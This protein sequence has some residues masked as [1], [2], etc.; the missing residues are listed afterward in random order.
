MVKCL[1]ITLLVCLGFDLHSQ[2]LTGEETVR[3]Y[4]S[5]QKRLLVRSTATFTNLITQ[6]NLDHDSVVLIACKVTGLPFLL[7]YTDDDDN[8]SPSP[9]AGLINAGKIPEA[10]HFLKGLDG[11]MRLQLSIELANW[12]LHKAGTHE[13]DLDSAN[14]FIQDALRISSAAKNKNKRYECLGLLGE[15]YRQIGDIGESKRTYFHLISSSQKEGD[16]KITASS[17]HH[18]ALLDREIDSTDLVYLDNSIVLYQQLQSKEKEIEILWMIASYHRIYDM[19]LYKKDLTRILE[20][21]QSIGFRHSLFAEYYLSLVDLQKAKYLDALEHANAAI[22]NMKWSRLSTMQGTFYMRL[23]AV[24]WGFEKKEEALVSFKK[25][26]ENRSDE[27]RIFWF[28]SLLFATSLLWEMNRPEESLSMMQDITSEFPP[29]TP[30]EQ[31]QIFSIKGVCYDKVNNYRLA[32]EN[33][34]AFLE[35]TNKY[36]DFDPY[37]ELEETYLEIAQFYLSKSN[38][39]T[40]RLFVNKAMS[41]SSQSMVGYAE[42]S[43]LLFK[44]DSIAGDYKS[45]MK[46]Y[47]QYKYFADIDKNMEQRKK[48]DEL[49][50]KYGAEKKDND[51]KLLQKE[52]QLQETMLLQAKYTRNWI[53]GGVALLLIIVGLLVYN[54]RLKQRTNKKLE[55]QQTEIEKQNFT[56]RH[57]VDEKDWLAKEIHHRVK[58]NLQIVMSLLNSQSAYIENDAALTAIHDS[59]HRVHAM[60]LIHQ[61][62]YNADNVSSIDMSF[63]IREL[64]SYLSD[65]FGTRQRILFEFAIEPLELDVSQAVPLGLILNEAITN[66]IKYAFPEGRSGVV[67]ISLFNTTSNNYLL[68]ISDNGIGIPSHLNDKKPGSLGMSLIAGLSEDLDGSFSIENNNGTTIKISFA[69]DPAVKRSDIRAVPFASNI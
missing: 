50:I 59:Q 53:L 30:W 11:E 42:K 1:T 52:K 25:A 56:L 62:L 54:T 5:A 63:Y 41:R 38:L 60:S 15:Y 7:A 51:I 65:S 8:E 4:S 39:K 55:S 2:L 58:N 49:N 32:D 37:K 43:Y 17:W 46:N 45:A 61:K 23:G 28:K 13:K 57:L 19:D 10:I 69:H 24:Y 27:T 26:L 40:A 67:S 29:I 64:T 34:M 12:F 16:K 47:I 21:Q 9:G 36:P 18:L 6:N 48:F 66:S 20:I 3:S 44:L 14:H 35:V 31:A 22:E 33:F 68:S